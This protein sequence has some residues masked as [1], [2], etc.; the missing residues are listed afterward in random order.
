MDN[1]HRTFCCCTTCERIAE[2]ERKC[3][4]SDRE[5]LLA[6]EENERLRKALEDNWCYAKSQLRA[7]LRIPTNRFKGGE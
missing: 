7:L 6:L 5:L 2:L 4:D 1:Q 3:D